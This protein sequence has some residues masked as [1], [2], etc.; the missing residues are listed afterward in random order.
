MIQRQIWLILIALSISVSTWAQ[1]PTFD[2]NSFVSP[3]SG[4]VPLVNSGDRWRW[5]V[6]TQLSSVVDFTPD[7]AFGIYMGSP[8]DVITVLQGDFAV[9][10]PDEPYKVLSSYGAGPCVI[11]ALIDDKSN[12]IGLTHADG[13]MSA[14][15][16]LSKILKRFTELQSFPTRAVMAGEASDASVLARW[17]KAL[18]NAGIQDLKF[19]RSAA[20]GVST[21][22]ELS[23]NLIKSDNVVPVSKRHDLLDAFIQDLGKRPGGY[24]STL[25]NAVTP[26]CDMGCAV[27]KVGRPAIELYPYSEF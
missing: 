14:G 2:P 4:R 17:T 26:Q 3:R 7:P 18:T 15:S 22:G 19:E 21:Q 10:S 9:L 1:V 11:V 16:S 5:E 6:P 12:V 27:E 20:L 8:K 13:L 25:T 23:N 24:M